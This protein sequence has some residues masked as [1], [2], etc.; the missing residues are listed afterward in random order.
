MG[1]ANSLDAGGTVSIAGIG[2]PR[3][4]LVALFTSTTLVVRGRSIG[5][6][7]D[8]SRQAAPRAAASATK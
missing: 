8:R 2:R 4:R 7:I 6:V 3:R 1:W 5:Q